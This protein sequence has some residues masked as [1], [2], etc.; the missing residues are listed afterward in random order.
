MLILF[1]ILIEKIEYLERHGFIFGVIKQFLK[2]GKIKFEEFVN[3]VH[4]RDPDETPEDAIHASSKLMVL[5]ERVEK[6]LQNEYLIPIDERRQR[7]KDILSKFMIAPMVNKA[8]EEMEDKNL[9][10][11]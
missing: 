4:K 11:F 1:Q 5:Q 2:N 3:Q 7:T 10:N 9:F 8:M 6:A